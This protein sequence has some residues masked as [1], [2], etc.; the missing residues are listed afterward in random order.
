MLD[1]F[2]YNIYEHKDLY[3][4]L[5]F[6]VNTDIIYKLILHEKTVYSKK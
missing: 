1:S 6:T 5:Y 4:G 2:I 3:L